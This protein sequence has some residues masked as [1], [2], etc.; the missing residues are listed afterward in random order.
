MDKG[1]RQIIFKRFDKYQANTLE[2]VI[3]QIQE[4]LCNIAQIQTCNPDDS[5]Y[6]E[7]QSSGNHSEGDEIN[8]FRKLQDQALKNS[9]FIY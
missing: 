1:Y 5:D 3:P 8:K 7:S 2:Q 6:L 9:S 4:R